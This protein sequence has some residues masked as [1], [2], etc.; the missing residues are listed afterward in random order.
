VR[1]CDACQAENPE[2]QRFCGSCGAPLTA[3]SVER[4]KLVTSVFCDLSGST[5]MGERAD[6]ETVFDLMRSYFDAARAA[7]ERHGGAVEKFIGDAVVGMFGVPEAHEDDALRACRAALEIQERVAALNVDLDDRFGTQIAVRI[8]VNTGEVVAG[9]AARRE[10]F[11]SGDAVVLGDAVNVAARLEQAAAPGEILLGETTY[12]LVRDAITA[13]PV[14]PIQAKGKSEPLSAYHLLEA[15][16]HGPI[17]RPAAGALVGRVHELALL[18]AEIERLRSEGRPRLV[19]IVGDAG[20]GKSRIAAETFARLGDEARIARG[21]CLSYGEG[22]TY[23][24][25]AQV[26]RDLAGARDDDTLDEAR[27]RFPLRIQQLLGLTEGT[28][29]AE[30][31]G[32]AVAEYLAAAALGR[33]LVVFIDDIHW[34]EPALLDL[35]ERLPRLLDT[36][37]VLILCLAR[38]ELADHRPGWEVTVKLDPLSGAQVDALLERL[39]APAGARVRIAHAAAGNPLYAEEL[40]AWVREGGDLD[41]LPT[42][43]NALLGARLDRLEPVERA[44]LERGAVE[45]ELF[46]QAAVV[47]LTDQPS[48]SAV[49]VG[50]GELTRK[51]MIRLAAT[52]LA[53]EMFAYRFKH[54]LVRDAAYRA[55]TKKLR[56]HLHERYAGWLEERAGDRVGEY[57]EILGYHL[58]QAYLYRAELGERDEALAVRAGR[59]LGAAGLRANDRADVRA[60][61]NLLGRA[62]KLLPPD[63]IERLELMRHHAYAVDQTGMMREAWAIS[64]ELHDRADALGEERLAA[65]GKSYATPH[66]FFAGDADPV[67]AAA[68]FTDVI[69]TFERLNDEAGLAAA[70]RR[71]ALVY[72]TQGRVETSRV[73]LEEALAHADACDDMST[74]RA[75]AYSLSND[76]SMGPMPVTEGIQRLEAL[77]LDTRDDAVLEAAVS[78]QLSLLYA[79]GGRF[80]ESRAIENRVATILQ[81]ASVESLSWGSLGAAARAKFVMGDIAGAEHDYRTKWRVYPVEDG[82]YQKLA[83]ASAF[84][85]ADL[86]CQ[87]RRWDE[88]EAVLATVRRETHEGAG[89]G[90]LA[91][92]RLATHYGNHEEAVTLARRTVERLDKTDY[93]PSRAE[94]WRA[95]TE[96]YRGAEM[97]DDAEL[98]LAMTFSLY[99]QKGNL[100]SAEHLRAAALVV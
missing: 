19:T 47:E 27:R 32:D 50:L 92:S 77:R 63:G 67:A 1:A 96:A 42:S 34:G 8:G 12:R 48:R 70:K 28:M 25:I 76:T 93:T 10:M 18:E 84:A 65:H 49:P 61:A 69:A 68:A 53:G 95:L 46:H 97:R 52:S 100:T 45:G 82:K 40:V 91:A 72:R 33:L 57:H 26:I 6:S 11:A 73:L 23:W 59:H 81:E 39:D 99:E 13:T 83:I 20:V 14:A 90:S 98:A 22:I 58:E 75:V 87:E 7:L 9:D 71:L 88:A 78:R 16:A 85:L 21:A 30:Q 2:G 35:L 64:R 4:R 80:E 56:A 15:S 62:T 79:M 89:A 55:T 36:A 17:P 66:P 94:A 38:P 43:L 29:T 41:A 5:E 3:P 51:D 44:A 37:P 86:Y 31:A 54:I 24:P 60:G 74:R